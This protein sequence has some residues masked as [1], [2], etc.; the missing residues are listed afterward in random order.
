MID[1]NSNC[2]RVDSVKALASQLKL[3]SAPKFTPADLSSNAAATSSAPAPQKIKSDFENVEAAVKANDAKK[4]EQALAVVRNDL[5]AAQVSK[6]SNSESKANDSESP[7]RGL[8]VY[9]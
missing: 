7:F 2:S 8:D 3:Q 5:A 1:A 4:A 6:N 9:A